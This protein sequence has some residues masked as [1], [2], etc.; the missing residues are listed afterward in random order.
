M[1]SSKTM[2]ESA[3]A[4]RWTGDALVLIDQ[5]WLPQRESYVRCTKLDQVVD[6]IKRM[7]VRGAPAIGIAAAYAGAL[8][9]RNVARTASIDVQDFLADLDRLALA[10]PTAVNLMWAVDAMKTRVHECASIKDLPLV[11]ERLAI[12]IHEE[13]VRANRTMAELA[14][15]YFR[16]EPVRPF[17][18][19]THCNTG[20]L[21]TGGLGTAL[22]VIRR[23]HQAGFVRH[24]Y[25][26]ET[27][28]WMQGARLT[29]WEL[30]KEGVPVSINTDAAG[31][32]II[33]NRD[34]KW[35]IVGA[36]RITANG[37]VANKI[38]TYNLAIVAR[39]H[40]C[41]FMVVAPS[42]T[43]DMYCASGALIHIEM[44]PASEIT[45]M[46]GQA[47][48]PQNA[49]ALNPVFDVTPASL[50]DVIVTERGVIEAP[51]KSKMAALFSPLNQ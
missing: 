4:L 45:H 27:R 28:P 2:T 13:D 43:V 15:A 10:R 33:Q 8:H 39:Y 31:A 3:E 11:L 38:G 1:E 14:L 35:V 51:N 5:R 17:S 20:A 12:S 34:V 49:Q 44:R 21:A 16:K 46:A 36:D 40:G 50:I 24:V 23:A 22:G 42:S 26:D 19:L 29:A 48:A 7:V 9:A 18:V 37:D 41:K 6:A 30:Q 47:F 25:A 32:W